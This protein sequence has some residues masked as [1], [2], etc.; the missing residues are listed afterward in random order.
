MINP[1]TVSFPVTSES[2]ISMQEQEI[3]R[4]ATATERELFVEVVNVANEVYTAA[5]VGDLGTVVQ[6]LDAVDYAARNDTDSQHLAALCRG[7]IA[8]AFRRA[9]V[10]KDASSSGRLEVGG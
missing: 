10:K 4:K 6:I 9:I 7:W 1:E 8:L 2:F 3:G 5:G